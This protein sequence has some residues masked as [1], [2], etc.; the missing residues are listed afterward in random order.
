MRIILAVEPADFRRKGVARKLITKLI[1]E[2]N[3][4]LKLNLVKDNHAAMSLYLDLGFKVFEEFEGKMYGRAIPAVRMKLI[5]S[6]EPV[7]SAER[8]RAR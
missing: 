2:H 6:A 3:H 1:E 7:I 4:H 5:K 8:L